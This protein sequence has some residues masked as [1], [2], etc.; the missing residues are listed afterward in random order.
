M[1]LFIMKSG[2]SVTISLF[3]SSLI[4]A[5]YGERV[6][7]IGSGFGVEA[8]YQTDDLFYDPDSGMHK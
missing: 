6:E 1:Y 3:L 5:G 8:K 4:Y 2:V 7:E